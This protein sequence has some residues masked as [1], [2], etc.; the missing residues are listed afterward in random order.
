MTY[1]LENQISIIEPH[2]FYYEVF[3]ISKKRGVDTNI[4]VDIINDYENSLLSYIKE[5]NNITKKA[6]AITEYGNDRSGFPTFYDS[7]Y[8]AIAIIN[9]CDFITADKKHYE[10][11]KDL[12]NIRLLESV[13]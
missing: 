9:N 10:K 1:I 2:I 7:V 6:L 12:G 4:V 8:H 5:D 3:G 13:I 11:T